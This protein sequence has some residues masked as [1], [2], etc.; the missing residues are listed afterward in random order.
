[1]KEARVGRKSGASITHTK[2]T[3]SLTRWETEKKGSPRV[4]RELPTDEDGSDVE[5]TGSGNGFRYWFRKQ[6][7]AFK[8][9]VVGE[10]GENG[11]GNVGDRVD[12]CM[13][14]EV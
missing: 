2:L 8:D 7:A 6:A 11:N 12:L 9:A 1:M 4:E 10:D 14:W 3:F 5:E 13:V